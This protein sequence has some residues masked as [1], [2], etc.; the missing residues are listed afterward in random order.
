MITNEK[1]KIKKKQ[2]Q[3]EQINTL[4]LLPISEIRGNTIILKDW[5]LRAIIKVWGLNLDLKNFEE[6]QIT[7]EQYKRFLNWLDFPIQILVRSTYLDITDYINFI[8]EKV[9]N[10]ENDILKWYWKEYL[11]FLEKINLQQW[12]AFSK[13]FY[14]IVPFYPV[15]DT[16]NIKKSWWQKLLDTLNAWET[17]EKIVSRY[18]QFKK[19][20]KHLDT[21]CNI[22]IEWLKSL[23][24]MAE[25]LELE[26]IIALLFKV[27]NPTSH[28]NQAE[29]V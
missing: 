25:R 26:E 2:N 18:R 7:I 20:N 21:R 10:I 5:W 8:N 19:N 4:K 27:Y 23:W 9:N 29:I 14:I 22:I 28:K 6:Q 24:I 1:E 13:E 17:P 16:T 12:I 15:N 3:Q 11:N